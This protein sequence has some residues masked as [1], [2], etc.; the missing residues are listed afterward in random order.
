MT[1]QIKIGDFTTERWRNQQNCEMSPHFVE[2]ALD[3]IEQLAKERDELQQQVQNLY[4]KTLEPD[5]RVDMMREDRD[6]WKARCEKLEKVVEA[7]KALSAAIGI[8]HHGYDIQEPYCKE[9]QDLIE[10]LEASE[11][12]KP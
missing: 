6:H 5:E 4:H 9:H 3:L 11:K 1:D 12:D 10:A 7:A 8:R 2:I